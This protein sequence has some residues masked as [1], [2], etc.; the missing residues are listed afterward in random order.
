LQV[1]TEWEWKWELAKRLEHIEKLL[2]IRPSRAIQSEVQR[3]QIESVSLERT[4]AWKSWVEPASPT[5]EKVR[6]G[7]LTIILGE[8]NTLLSPV[9]RSWKQ[10]LNRDTWTLT[11][12]MK[13][14]DLIDIYRT[15]YPKTKGYSSQSH[16][17]PIQNWPYNWLQNRHQEIQKYWNYPMHPIWSE[18]TKAGLQ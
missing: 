7:E 4:L 1:K 17:V 6:K 14:M 2:F 15:F 11:E 5:S 3:S 8:F 10:K 9:D 18:R 12:I 13:Q 16:I